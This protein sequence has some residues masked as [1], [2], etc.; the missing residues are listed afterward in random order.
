MSIPLGRLT[1]STPSY[2]LVGW[3]VST[4]AH[5]AGA[6]VAWATWTATVATDRPELF[7]KNTHVK[8]VAAWS[9]PE[10]PTAAVEIAPVEARVLVMPDR[11]RIAERTYLPS[12]TDVSQ[13][14]PT[15]LAMA[16]RLI[17]LPEP[18]ARRSPVTSPEESVR[19]AALRSR[20]RRQP[21]P[22][23]IP[24]A[25]AELSASALRQE[26]V[27][28]TDKTPP[29]LLDNRPPTYPLQAVLDRFQGTVTLRVHITSE[30]HV[31]KLE[32]L[33]SSGHAILDAAAVRAVR[34]WRFAPA[35]RGGR[36][37]AATV[38]LPVRFV[39]DT[40]QSRDRW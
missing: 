14:T 39:L 25:K 7:G 23:G 19:A 16:D 18:S 38:H 37:V 28:T 40:P 27:G 2:E 36:P 6:V 5:V 15:E 35:R 21:M 3:G 29:R 12:S 10:P 9:Q 1:A 33:L 34:A 30:G 11:V 26:S 31:A 22:P 17:T 20:I 8:L 4:V 13:P 24:T 32:I